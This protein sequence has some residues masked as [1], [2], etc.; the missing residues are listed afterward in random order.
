MNPAPPVISNRIGQTAN[1][2]FAFTLTTL[3]GALAAG[4]WTTRP[5]S[6]ATAP[7]AA[8]RYHENPFSA[9]RLITLR[10]G[11]RIAIVVNKAHR[12]TTVG[13]AMWRG[14]WVIVAKTAEQ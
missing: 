7:A 3:A 8:D 11:V 13:I 12:A 4:G 1:L 9:R 14:Y 6:P 10:I 2:S 5:T